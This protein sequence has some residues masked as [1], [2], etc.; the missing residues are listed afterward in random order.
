MTSPPPSTNTVH[1]PRASPGFFQSAVCRV[2]S[3]VIENNYLLSDIPRLFCAPAQKEGVD[4]NEVA[5][6]GSS[7]IL[8]R[9]Q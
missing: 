6:R 7:K 9:M 3:A 8:L 4:C 5:R 1:N 2:Q